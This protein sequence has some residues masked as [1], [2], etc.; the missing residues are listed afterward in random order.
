MNEAKKET[1]RVRAYRLVLRGA[2]NGELTSRKH[3]LAST[4]RTRIS[5][6][7]LDMAAKYGPHPEGDWIPG[8]QIG[9]DEDG[10]IFIWKLIVPATALFPEDP[11][12]LLPENKEKPLTGRGEQRSN[13]TQSAFSF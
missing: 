13:T 6:L 2:T 8:R 9:R 12:E 4:Y 1:Q 10:T 11:L 3:G 5:E 7:R